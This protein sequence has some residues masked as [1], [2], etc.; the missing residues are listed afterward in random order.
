MKEKIWTRLVGNKRQTNHHTEHWAQGDVIMAMRL[1][2]DTPTHLP[3]EALKAA[4]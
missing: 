1:T 4:S 3:P 2:V